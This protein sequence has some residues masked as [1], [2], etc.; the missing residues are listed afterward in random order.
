MSRDPAT[1]E[2][3]G[4]GYRYPS[5]SAWGLRGVDLVVEPGERLLLLGPS[6]AG[7]STLLQG[8]A[9]LLDQDEA[10]ASEGSL[11]IGG[12]VPAR[13]RGRVGY[14]A[15]DP[16]SQ[17]VMARCGDDVAFGLENLG[18]PA[19]EIW[20]RAREAMELVG[21]PYSVDH[22]TNQLSGGEKQRLVL[23]GVLALRPSVLL[24][25]EP[26]ANLDPDG[27]ATIRR[28]VEHVIEATGA[29]LILVEHR[30][31]VWRDLVRRV[32][33]L[34]PGGGVVEDRSTA[35]LF[36][37]SADAELVERG[38]WAPG[39]RPLTRRTGEPSD[40]GTPLLLGRDLR[41]RYPGAAR[42]AVAL[43]RVELRTG[44]VLAVRGRNGSGKSTLA[45]LLA[46]L[47]CPDAGE[48]RVPDRPTPLHR[49]RAR[50]LVGEV[51]TVFQDPEHQFLTRSVRDELAFG[52]RRVGLDPAE[53]E[54]RTTEL[55]ERL[56]LTGVAG[57]N[58]FTLSGGEKR[59]LSVATALATRPRALVLDEP[60]FGQDPQTWRE[61]AEMLIGLRADGHG[62]CCVSHDPDFV[63]DLADRELW[64]DAGRVLT[65]AA[66]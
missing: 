20:P 59:R 14:V 3:R 53:I 13:S 36:D 38:V 64:L 26:T 47:V 61:L 34:E 19:S 49:W 2:A 24:L 33:V 10:E 51:G 48:V 1:V 55:L 18:V 9:G 27:G 62:V 65:E 12:Q 63:A 25:D 17:L 50:E 7:K 42:D 35:D 66:R 43:D 8:L 16:E 4:W 30:L 6:G 41:L 21:F 37:G 45:M 52:P 44:E 11:T 46:G 23:A 39:Y 58:P 40:T 54:R 56:R 60:T 29:T 22:P 5:R 32:V 15:Q 57:A 31:E 28:T